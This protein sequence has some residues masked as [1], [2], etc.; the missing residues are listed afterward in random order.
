[1][2]Q[3]FRIESSRPRV[4]LV[5]SG[6]GPT[7]GGIGVVSATFAAALGRDAHVVVW[8][9]RPTW[10]SGVRSLALLLRVMAGSLNPPDFIL[11]THVDLA[12][13]MMFA[14]LFRSVPY[15]VLI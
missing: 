14:R 4:A 9:H 15:G 7:L 2:S 10:P 3:P 13:T 1:M 6:L 11:F 5:T 8:R 12:R